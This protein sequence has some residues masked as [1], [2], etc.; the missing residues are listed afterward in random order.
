MLRTF[1]Y[2]FFS[3]KNAK[4]VFFHF[5]LLEIGVKTKAIL[6]KVSFS[7]SVMSTSSIICQIIF[8]RYS[9]IALVLIL[10]IQKLRLFTYLY[11]STVWY[12]FWVVDKR[13]D[14]IFRPKGTISIGTVSFQKSYQL[15]NFQHKVQ[16][17]YYKD[18]FV[19]VNN[20]L[21]YKRTL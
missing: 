5:S 11:L 8:C 2:Y 19:S 18:D 13:V 7:M 15:T 17:V 12:R 21:K 3:L 10:I 6:I 1:A 16:I 4:T 9:H 14:T 20:P